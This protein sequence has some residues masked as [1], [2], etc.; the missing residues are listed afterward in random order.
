MRRPHKGLDKT[1]RRILELLQQN[2]RLSNVDLARDLG[3]SA[4][5]V[6]S[7]VRN[8]EER[9]VIQ[10]YYARIDPVSLDLKLLAFIF[11]KTD[12]L[13]KENL[14]GD[15]ISRLSGVLEVHDIVGED[16]LLVKVR[17]SGTEDLATL[18]REEFAKIDG[19]ISTN[20]TIV[21]HTIVESNVLPVRPAA[22]KTKSRPMA[23][24]SRPARLF[25]A[26]KRK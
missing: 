9:G 22:T 25:Q 16:A 3:L 19:I 12:N 17:T 7:R 8:L 10:A 21:L 18:I 24:R 6:L 11:V 1:D 14:A 15:Q 2:G 5:S 26:Q 20:T 23:K 13:R 4:P